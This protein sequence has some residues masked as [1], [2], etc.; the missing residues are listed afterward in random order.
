VA[1]DVNAL[2]SLREAAPALKRKEHS[3]RRSIAAGDLH[4]IRVGARWYL[5]SDEIARIQREGLPIPFS[6]RKEA[7]R[8]RG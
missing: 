1:I 5:H 3:L 8:K 6:T 7:R 4:A 2:H